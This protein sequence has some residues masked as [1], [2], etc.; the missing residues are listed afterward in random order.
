MK[1][2]NGKLHFPESPVAQ[3]LHMMQVAS[4]SVLAT[5]FEG[6]AVVLSFLWLL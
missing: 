4:T 6:E 5:R 2:G 3:I 1:L